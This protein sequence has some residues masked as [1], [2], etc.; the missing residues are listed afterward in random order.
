MIYKFSGK[1]ARLRISVEYL[2]IENWSLNDINLSLEYFK[3]V[4]CAYL[5]KIKF[6]VLIFQICSYKANGM[7]ELDSCCVLLIHTGSISE[8]FH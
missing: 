6:R 2:R 4:N 5:I 7:T 8:L 1:K 3:D